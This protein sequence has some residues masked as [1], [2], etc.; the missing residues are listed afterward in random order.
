MDPLGLELQAR[1]PSSDPLQEQQ[2]LSSAKLSLHPTCKHFYRHI[3]KIMKRA[4]TL[5]FISFCLK[6][7]GL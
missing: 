5:K 3:S 4:F 2:A 7:M 1:K 6:E